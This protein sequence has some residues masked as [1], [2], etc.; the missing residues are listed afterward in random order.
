VTTVDIC[1]LRNIEVWEC[2]SNPKTNTRCS[3][4]VPGDGS[5]T[6][7]IDSLLHS[8]QSRTCRKKQS[9]IWRRHLWT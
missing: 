7:H 9:Q 6:A 2:W 5:H 3:K 4:R 8:K 1:N